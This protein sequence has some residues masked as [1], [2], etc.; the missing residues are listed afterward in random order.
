MRLPALPRP[1]IPW[2]ARWSFR[3]YL[4][5]PRCNA[6]LSL[7]SGLI[8]LFLT[9]KH[10]PQSCRWGWQFLPKSLQWLYALLSRRSRQIFTTNG[11]TYVSLPCYSRNQKGTVDTDGW[12]WRCR[13]ALF[14]RLNKDTHREYPLSGNFCGY[15][16]STLH[17]AVLELF[18]CFSLWEMVVTAYRKDS[19]SL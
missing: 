5:W 8:V 6:L 1:C 16:L 15:T 18:H 10:I 3:G 9:H 2:A 12:E 17:H 11:Y 19:P 14:Y 4:P 13:S 7:R